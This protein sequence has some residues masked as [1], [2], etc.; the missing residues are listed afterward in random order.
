MS[1][2]NHR[3]N[4]AH[5][6]IFFPVNLETQVRIFKLPE[7][8]RV[9]SDGHPSRSL[10]KIRPLPVAAELRQP[11]RLVADHDKKDISL[12]FVDNRPQM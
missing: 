11:K 4:Y 2:D 1:I 5:V 7:A 3:E 9:A 12:D 6:L 10:L 8:T